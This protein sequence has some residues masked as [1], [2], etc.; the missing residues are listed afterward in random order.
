[1]KS[2][3][4]ARRGASVTAQVFPGVSF[5]KGGTDQ[6]EGGDTTS[7]M[8]SNVSEGELQKAGRRPGSST[9]RQRG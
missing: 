1:V 3:S 2:T 7:V 5:D 4:S 8:W 9:Q 6:G